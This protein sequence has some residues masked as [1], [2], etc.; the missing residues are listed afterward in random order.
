M[1]NQNNQLP[2]IILTNNT[3]KSQVETDNVSI[4]EIGLFNGKIEPLLNL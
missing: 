3:V 4:W 2:S 1:T